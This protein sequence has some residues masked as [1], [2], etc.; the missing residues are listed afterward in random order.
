M[1][2]DEALELLRSTHTFPGPYR[3]RVV[4]PPGA[5]AAL[6]AAVAG[7]VGEVEV[8]VV[9]QPSRTGAW[10]SY[11]LQALLGSAEAVLAVYAAVRE[12]D[13]VRAVM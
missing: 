4:A 13:G 11:R 3:F 9:E 12:V 1:D 8:D 2:R 5:R 7:V 6:L 10:I